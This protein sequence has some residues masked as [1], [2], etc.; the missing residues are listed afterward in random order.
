MTSNLNNDSFVPSYEMIEL[1][2]WLQKKELTIQ[3]NV[4]EKE[5][6]DSYFVK[7]FNYNPF[8]EEYYA[9]PSNRIQKKD[10]KEL[11]LIFKEKKALFSSYYSDHKKF[12]Q[13][14]GE[15]KRF[16]DKVRV[17]DI[18][19]LSPDA[20][21]FYRPFHITPFDQWGIYLIADKLISYFYYIKK[22]FSDLILFSDNLLAAYILFEIFH[23]EFYHHIVESTATTIELAHHALSN[24]N[25]KFYTQHLRANYHPDIKRHP[26]APLEE[27]LANAYA[28]NSFSFLTSVSKKPLLYGTINFYKEMMKRYWL[29]EPEGYKFAGCYLYGDKINGSK[30]ILYYLFNNPNLQ[31]PLSILANRVFPKGHTAFISKPEIPVYLV[32]NEENIKKIYE[33]VPA[34]NEAYTNLYW[35]GETKNLNEYI[36]EKKKEEKQMKSKNRKNKN[37][38][39][40]FFEN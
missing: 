36:K 10:R 32:G 16:K 30:K 12:S 26:H 14:Y 40:S 13:M 22:M 19:K 9:L 4:Y 39:P 8:S 33:L 18:K 15:I 1:F 11:E 23:H 28:F 6:D 24:E 31:I 5:I 3:G 34:P 35:P 7:N 25:R 17:L 29:T 2:E 38:Q 20:M 27:A 21:A 37:I